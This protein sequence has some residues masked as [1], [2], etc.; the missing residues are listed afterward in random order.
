MLC[1]TVLSKN[2]TSCER[3]RNSYRVL[4][5]SKLA[6]I[7]FSVYSTCNRPETEYGHENMFLERTICRKQSRG[8]PVWQENV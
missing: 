7:M 5:S 8:P 3:P 4:A 6:G 2:A 1:S